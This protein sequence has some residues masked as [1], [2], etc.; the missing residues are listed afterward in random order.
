MV[1]CAEPPEATIVEMLKR[2]SL[3]GPFRF[4]VVSA[5]CLAMSPGFAQAAESAKAA[6]PV[7]PAKAVADLSRAPDAPAR[8][9][10]AGPSDENANRNAGA[11]TRMLECGHQWSAMKKAGTASGTWKDFSR[12]CLVRK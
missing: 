12:V 2:F 7:S 10:A 9:T 5:F 1:G 11:R 6:P 4:V 3:S 8:S